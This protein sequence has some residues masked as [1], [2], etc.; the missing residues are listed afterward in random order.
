MP[1]K[2]LQRKSKPKSLG[3]QI[4]GTKELARLSVE[5]RARILPNGLAY[6]DGSA[7]RALEMIKSSYQV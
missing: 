5:K 1:S 6:C 3:A 4:A 2:N 7:I